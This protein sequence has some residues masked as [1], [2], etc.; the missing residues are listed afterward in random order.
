MKKSTNWGRARAKSVSIEMKDYSM[1]SDASTTRSKIITNS[2]L[3]KEDHQTKLEFMKVEYKS[4]SSHAITKCEAV[5]N[6]EAI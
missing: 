3:V 6:V 2:D 4:G 1:H 5:E